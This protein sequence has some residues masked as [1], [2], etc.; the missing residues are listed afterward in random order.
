MKI[1][2]HLNLVSSVTGQMLKTI[3]YFYTLA[4]AMTEKNRMLTGLHRDHWLAIDAME[5][6]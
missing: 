6:E 2:Y 5:V 3:G 4:A 1:L